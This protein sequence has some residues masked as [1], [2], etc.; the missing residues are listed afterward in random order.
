MEARRWLLGVAGRTNAVTRTLISQSEF[1]RRAQ[2]GQ[3]RGVGVF[4]DATEPP[5]AVTGAQRTLRFCFSDG[6]VDRMG[7]TIN[8]HGWETADFERNPVALWAH[9][10]SEPPIGRASNLGVERAR[11]MGDIEFAAPETYEFA[12]TIYRLVL[13]K[14]IR[15]VSV[16]FL[17]IRYVFVDNDPARGW[18]VDYLEQSLLE[19]SVCPVPANANALAEARSKGIDT[20]SLS[21][22]AERA[23][24]HGG[25]RTVSDT[26][27][28]RLRVAAR[29]PPGTSRS[30][31]AD[32][33]TAARI[34]A[35]Y[36]RNVSRSLHSI[37]PDPQVLAHEERERSRRRDALASADAVV[38]AV[39]WW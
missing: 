36:D 17:P 39:Q 38:R 8:P 4:R 32:L 29:E 20:R 15:A 25:V 11:L 19:I 23:L 3:V 30:R 26:A 21:R 37:Q 27:L 34:K 24:D 13:G 18:G 1:H 12:D 5:I 7:D 2:A 22:W 9:D 16:G 28:A 33:A 14:F 35:D 10:S 6:T 31:A